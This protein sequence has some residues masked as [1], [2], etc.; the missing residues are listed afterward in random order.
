MGV[1]SGEAT[2]AVSLLSPFT[3]IVNFLLLN[4]DQL[5]KKISPLEANSINLCRPHFGKGMSQGS[6]EEVVEVVPLCI[7]GEDRC[8]CT[9]TL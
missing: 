7:S 6:K 3:M 4:E 9:Q 1:F 5:L 8:R 2:L